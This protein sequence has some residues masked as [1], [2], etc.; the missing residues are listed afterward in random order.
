MAN[1]RPDLLLAVAAPDDL[2]FAVKQIEQQC[3]ALRK[4]LGTTGKYTPGTPSYPTDAVRKRFQNI[5]NLAD[6]AADEIF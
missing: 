5:A 1:K 6:A 3:V 2:L 4:V